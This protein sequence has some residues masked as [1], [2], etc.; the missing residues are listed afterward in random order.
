MDYITHP[1][2]IAHREDGAITHNQANITR[3]I[4]WIYEAATDPK[5]MNNLGD[6]LATVF[7]TVSSTLFLVENRQS[8]GL[9]PVPTLTGVFYTTQD[10]DDWAAAAYREYYH[11]RNEWF[12]R[13]IKKP[14]P[15]IVVGRELI[16]D[17]T[18]T[19][20][21]FCTDWCSRIDVFHVLG[22]SFP[23]SSEAVGAIGFHRSRR[24]G[25]FG[26]DDK[27]RLGVLLPHLQ[28]AC[29]IHRRLSIAEGREA[30]F[31]Q[32]VES[33]RVGV[34]IVDAD[35]QV[36]FANR[37]ADRTL[38][39]GCAIGLSKGR[40]HTP[41]RRCAP[42]LEK[43]VRE[44]AWTSAGQGTG[45]GAIVRVC[46]GGEVALVLLVAP[47][48]HAEIGYGL[49]QPAALILFGGPDR[50]REMPELVLSRLY[51]LTVAESQLVSALMSGHSLVSYAAAAGI[52][53]NTA[54]THLDHVFQKTGHHRQVDLIRMIAEDPLVKLL[55]WSTD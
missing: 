16:D 34:L 10:M 29:Q 53:V 19:R 50:E 32:I 42:A 41:D 20:T 39:L 55:L 8:A 40:L 33:L 3:A 54:N 44:A 24:A 7:D 13:G 35:C 36:L 28:R 52:S 37:L 30:A 51:G 26:R 27:R 25:A 23:I 47:L 15:A 31:A 4:G 46:R 11:E 48:R 12:A 6:L 1:I 43:A 5:R 21:E 18:F 14:V 49:A 17:A 22:A 45:A 9:F 38:E 2:T